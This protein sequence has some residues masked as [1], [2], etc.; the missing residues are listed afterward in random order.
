MS[1]MAG[2]FTP[3]PLPPPPPRKWPWVLGAIGVLAIGITALIWR[4][5]PTE[6]ERQYFGW[7][8]GWERVD[9]LN[10]RA[11]VAEMRDDGRIQIHFG[12]YMRP[13]VSAPWKFTTSWLT[14]TWRV[15]GKMQRFLTEDPEHPT[16]TWAKIQ[17][18]QETG[19]WRQEQFYRTIEINERQMRYEEVQL[20]KVYRSLRSKTPVSLPNEPSDPELWK[21]IGQMPGA[22][23]PLR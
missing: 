22:K 14:G 5:F 9:E 16:N 13:R 21:T 3:P 1:A 17:R 10:A 4:P 19:H 2:E 11:W 20:G 18:I 12:H 15:R 7:W 23:P 8:Y 6:E